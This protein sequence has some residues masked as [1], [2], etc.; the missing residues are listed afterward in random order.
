MATNP[1]AQSQTSLRERQKQQLKSELISTALQIIEEKGLD[2]S[3]VDEIAARAGVAKGTFYLYFKAKSDIISAV[4]EDS[5]EKFESCISSVLESAPEDANDALRTIVQAQSAFIEKNP[6]L[7]KLL[8][9]ALG[10]RQVSDEARDNLKIRYKAVT[11]AIYE[12]LI[13]KGMLQRHFREVD[14][15]IA[16]AA[17]HAMFSSLAIDSIDSSS[18]NEACEAALDIFSRGIKHGL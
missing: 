1:E 13:R 14:A 6:A 11:T 17:L 8:I 12:R 16:A 4:I 10:S 15:S 3:S 9:S 18:V 2:A 5:I 7:F